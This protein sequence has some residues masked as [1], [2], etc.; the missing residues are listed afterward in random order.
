M[1]I[2]DNTQQTNTFLKGMNTDISDALIGDSEYRLAENLRYVT[3]TESNTGEL[4]LIEGDVACTLNVEGVEDRSFRILAATSIRD[5]IILVVKEY[6]TETYGEHSIKIYDGWSVLKGVLEDVEL[7]LQRSFGPCKEN[8]SSNKLSLVTRWEDDDNVKLYIADGEHPLMVVNVGGEESVGTTIAD[9]TNVRNAVLQ[10]LSVGDYIEGSLK[11]AIVQYS[12]RLYNTNGV[13]TNVS[14]VTHLY[15]IHDYKNGYVYGYRQGVKTSRGFRLSG[16]IN[17]DFEKIQLYRITYEMNGQE[18]TIELIYQ[19][20]YDNNF[21][22]DD[23]GAQAL[24]SMSLAEYNSIAGI[25]IIP[26][27][28]E[29]KNNYLFAGNIKYEHWT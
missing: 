7:N 12:Y 26:T 15:K 28:I 19:G 16:I 22:Y 11:P 14:P 9:I 21:T 3:N 24:S 17:E 18:P 25:N 13:S 29:S 6:V 20:K 23:R 10:P 2:N 5:L 4:R 27:V 1:D 8:L